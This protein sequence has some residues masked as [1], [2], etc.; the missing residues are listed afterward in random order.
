VPRVGLD[1]GG[2]QAC[3]SFISGGRLPWDLRPAR[4][5]HHGDTVVGMRAGSSLSPP[6]TGIQGAR[7][8]GADTS[9]GEL[10]GKGSPQDPERLPRGDSAPHPMTY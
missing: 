5:C 7:G 10:P 1:E 9:Q 8:A 6:A 3:F 2:E 4:H